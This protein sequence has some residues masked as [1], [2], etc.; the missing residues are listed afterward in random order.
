MNIRIV[1][2]L[3]T[4]PY[5]GWYNNVLCAAHCFSVDNIEMILSAG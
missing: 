3:A 4:T 5:C 1:A 2:D